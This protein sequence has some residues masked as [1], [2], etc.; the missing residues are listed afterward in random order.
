MNDELYYKASRYFRRRYG[1]Y[2]QRLCID[3]GFTCPNRDGRC[4]TGG[5]I[6]CGERGAGDYLNRRLTVREQVMKRIGG[7]TGRKRFAAYFQS[8]TGTYAPVERL[9]ELYDEALCSDLILALAVA[10][11]PDCIDEDIAALLE[12]YKTR[13]DVWAE[14]GLQTADDDT[15]RFINRGY[16]TEVFVKAC[17]ILAAHGIPVVAHIMIGLPGEDETHLAETVRLINSCKV[18]GIK[19]HSVYVM[20]DTLLERLYSEGSYSPPTLE[21]Y[22]RGA[23]YV[24][25]HISPDTVVHRITGDCPPDLLVAPEWSSDKRIVKQLIHD[26]MQDKG[27][28][29]GC[30][31]QRT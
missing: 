15:A 14:L 7:Y 26:T 8:F 31:Y 4:G 20:K 13:C 17:D 19:L 25:T 12:S 11:R 3:G 6:F 1:K 30:F 18:W 10:T 16:E 21:E 28:R 9:K 29:Q 2:V 27:L 23:V 5:C 22:V 24:L